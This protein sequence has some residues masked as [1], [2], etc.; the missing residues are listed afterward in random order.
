MKIPFTHKGWFGICPIYLADVDS[1]GP[2]IEPRFMFTGWL[3][4]L[5]TF[6]YGSCIWF[7]TSINPEFEPRW[8]MLITGA[9]DK[10]IFIEVD[11]D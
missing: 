1:D 3:I 8:P 9:L 5:S 7:I 6:I 4:H 11:H 2:R 10:P